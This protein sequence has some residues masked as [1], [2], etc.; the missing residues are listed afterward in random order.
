MKK[1]TR[2]IAID[3]AGRKG[4]AQPGIQVAEIVKDSKCSR[5][6]NCPT[7]RR[8]SRHDVANFIIGLA[9]EP[10]LVG[11]DFA[12]SIPWQESRGRPNQVGD[13]K[14]LWAL[15]D[16]I[17]AD[18]PHMY[19]GP[20]WASPQSPFRDYIFHHQSGHHGKRYYREN[21]RAVE[22]LEMGAI[23]VYHMTGAQ[24]GMG[25]FAGMRMLH[26][27]AQ[28]HSSK[29]AIWPFD[30][31]DKGKTAI[32]EIYP[33]FFYRK[34]RSR[35]PTKDELKEGRFEQIDKTLKHYECERAADTVCRSVDQADALVSA[36]A[37]R[38]I[39]RGDPFKLPENY[40]FD[41]REGWIFGVPMEVRNYPES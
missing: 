24:V 19:A 9:E 31:V 38:C 13:A 37:L 2:F 33:S 1:F 5:L 6:V 11:L 20:I 15:V 39:A 18:T 14:E 41:I 22:A 16:L 8:W 35:R 17:C 34:A 25:S 4:H 27:F 32:V 10:T 3:W 30:E 12:F 23:S 26:Q 40:K 29:I 7:G 28:S 21:W 36:A